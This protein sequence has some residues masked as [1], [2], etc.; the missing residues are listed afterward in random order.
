MWWEQTEHVVTKRMIETMRKDDKD[1]D[2]MAT[3]S[4][5]DQNTE[6][7]KWKKGIV[8]VF[9]ANLEQIFCLHQVKK[10]GSER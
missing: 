10:T 7:K 3:K 5:Y 2:K 4:K 8:N 6:D 9:T 1:G